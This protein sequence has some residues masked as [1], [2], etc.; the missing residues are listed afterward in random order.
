MAKLTAEQ[1]RVWQRDWM[2]ERAAIIQYDGGKPKD[3]AEREA[4]KQYHE[5]H[6]KGYFD[7]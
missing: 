3:V 7:A 4:I 1:L 6:G 5:Q 2:E